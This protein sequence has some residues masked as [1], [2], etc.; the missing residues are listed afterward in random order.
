[1][2][3][4]ASSRYL[5]SGFLRCGECGASI[6]IVSGRSGKRN[7]RY[8]CPQNFY[9]GACTNNLKERHDWLENRLLAELQEAVL[10]PEAIDYALAEFGRQLTD[11]LANPLASWLDS[12][13]ASRS[14]KPSWID[15]LRLSPRQG[16]P[17]SC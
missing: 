16:I 10:K 11:A 9:R 14:F 12:A 3:R 17:R 8:G 7:P 2:N 5:L 6:V 13:S 4:S 1:M 15:S